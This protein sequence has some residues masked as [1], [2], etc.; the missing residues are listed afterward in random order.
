MTWTAGATQV[1]G[2]IITASI[3]NQYMGPTGSI[4]HL[5][6]GAHEHVN[7]EAVGT[8]GTANLTFT[9]VGAVAY[10]SGK[11]VVYFNGRVVVPTCTVGG[12]PKTYITFNPAAGSFTFTADWQTDILNGA[13][14]ATTDVIS[15]TCLIPA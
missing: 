11:I 8:K 6:D 2:T 12:T 10:T 9:T 1:T 4:E 13:N 14:I 3:W 7:L 5:H 15:Y